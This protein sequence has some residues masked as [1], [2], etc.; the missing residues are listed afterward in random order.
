[1]MDLFD[2]A[3]DHRG[4]T[5]STQPPAAVQAALDAANANDTKA[6][7]ACFPADGVVDDWG[8]EFR[9][10]DRIREWSD[11][12]FIGVKVSLR[13]TAVATRGDDVVVT[14]EVGGDG[15]NGESHFTFHVAGDQV[16]RM[17]IRA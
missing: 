3:F 10:H 4:T 7:L 11:G 1:M 6:F 16:T 8:R 9:G 17:T 2:V 15:F 5:M 14:A 12:E 13:V